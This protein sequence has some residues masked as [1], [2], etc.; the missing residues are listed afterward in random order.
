M[1]LVAALTCR[2]SA[3]RGSPGDLFDKK[4]S[5]ETKR[6]DVRLTRV[7][8]QISM[9]GRAAT[10]ILFLALLGFAGGIAASRARST[11]QSAAQDQ[12]LSDEERARLLAKGKALFVE[13]CA[14]CHNERGEKPLKTGPPL[15]ERGLS[16]DVI[17][18]AVSGRLRDKTEDERRAVTLY[19][20]SLMKTKDSES[21][22]PKP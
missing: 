18:R 8:Y 19:I 2:K 22:A 12:P 13:R 10:P 21:S 15:N 4:G 7:R 3:R 1:D 5:A 9:R 17:A 6:L 16:A 14:R 20:F 11:G